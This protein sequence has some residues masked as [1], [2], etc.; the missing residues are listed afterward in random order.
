MAVLP[1]DLRRSQTPWRSSPQRSQ[2]VQGSQPVAHPPDRPRRGS[3]HH[4]EPWL[5]GPLWTTRRTQGV[6]PTHHGD[7]A[8]FH[9][10]HGEYVPSLHVFDLSKFPMERLWNSSGW[11]NLELHGITN[12][13][14]L[15]LHL[16]MVCGVYGSPALIHVEPALWMFFIL[17]HW[18]YLFAIALA[19]LTYFALAVSLT[20]YGWCFGALPNCLGNTS[21]GNIKRAIENLHLYWAHYLM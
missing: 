18:A 14:T 20:K 6:V 8:G 12:M 19:F 9:A 10:H 5:P 16:R 11:V 3:L 4:H 13:V 15:R 2:D 17:L 21:F 1:S 7:G